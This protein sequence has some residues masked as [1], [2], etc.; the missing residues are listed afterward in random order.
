MK[1]DKPVANLPPEARPDPDRLRFDL[2]HALKAMVRL[3]IEVSDE[4]YTA[5]ILGTERSGHGCVIGPD[6]LVLTIGYLITE[7]QTIWITDHRGRTVPGY[8]LGVDFASGLGLVLPAMPLDAPALARG[9][10]ASVAVG[11]EVLV[12]GHGGLGNALAARLEERRTFAG[13]WE[14]VLE[15]AL[16]T[17]PAHPHWSGAAVVDPRGQLI[18][19]GSLFVQEPGPGGA[20]PMNMS[21]PVELLEPILEDLRRHG[22]P[23]Q[24]PRPWLGFFVQEDEGRLVVAG[25]ATRGPAARAGIE[26]GDVVEAVA[27]QRVSSM[28]DLFRAIWAQGPAGTSIAL[29]LR[30]KGKPREVRVE[31]IDRDSILWRPKGLN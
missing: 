17:S 18:G 22:R 27:G 25:L 31:S 5:P 12:L 9:V 16:Y 13:Y 28:V 2:D 10:G 20:Q 1:P 3:S 4:A 26:T 8:A 14:Y 15:G 30:R 29:S 6:G 23:N 21:V 19:V 24:P 7:A 11:D